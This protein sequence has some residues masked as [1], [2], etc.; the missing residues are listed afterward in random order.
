MDSQLKE[1]YMIFIWLLVFIVIGHLVSDY[2][3]IQLTEVV[4]SRKNICGITLLTKL[5]LKIWF[6]LIIDGFV[7]GSIFIALGEH[8]ILSGMITGYII[9]GITQGINFFKYN[10]LVK[11]LKLLNLKT[12]NEVENFIDKIGE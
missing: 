4:S 3:T 7:L 10:R 9:S 6:G 5:Y 11:A 8:S 2:L 12:D 1:D